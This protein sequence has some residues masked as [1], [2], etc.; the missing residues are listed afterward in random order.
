MVKLVST[1][2]ILSLP[3][4]LSLLEVK[5]FITLPKVTGD[6]GLIDTLRT[7]GMKFLCREAVR[8]AGG[9]GSFVPRAL[10]CWDLTVKQ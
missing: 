9:E 3:L 7:L 2:E 8:R 4:Y 5:G 10:L 1:G 6:T